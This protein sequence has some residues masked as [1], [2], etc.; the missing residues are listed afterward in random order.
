[1]APKGLMLGSGPAAVPSLPQ[2]QSP[3]KFLGVA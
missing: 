1:M 2:H 3:R